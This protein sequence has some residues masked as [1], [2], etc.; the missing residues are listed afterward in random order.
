[1]FLPTSLCQRSHNH[2]S[3]GYVSPQSTS[4]ALGCKTN[5]STVIT[6]TSSSLYGLYHIPWPSSSFADQFDSSGT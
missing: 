6:G 3:E 1:M 2:L 5:H 4:N